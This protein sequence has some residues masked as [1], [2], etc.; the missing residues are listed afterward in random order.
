MSN[1]TRVAKKLAEAVKQ[2]RLAYQFCPN[3]YTHTAFQACLAAA[4]ALNV[5]VDEEIDHEQIA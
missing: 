4:E 3:S 2:T 5:A 1:K